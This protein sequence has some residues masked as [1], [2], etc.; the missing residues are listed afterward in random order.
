MSRAVGLASSNEVTFIAELHE[1]GLP[2][3]ANFYIEIG[4]NAHTGKQCFTRC[5]VSRLVHS[6]GRLASVITWKISTRDPGIIILGSQLTGLAWLSYNR[7]VV[8]V[9]VN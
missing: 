3:A 6:L 8:F 7:K 5:P 2:A 9:C 1:K 4:S